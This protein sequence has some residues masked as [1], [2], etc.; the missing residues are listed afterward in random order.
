MTRGVGSIHSWPSE[1]EAVSVSVALEAI[2]PT[3]RALA[4][5][6]HIENRCAWVAYDLFSPCGP[7][8]T[9]PR[10]NCANHGVLRFEL[11]L[12]SLDLT[13]RNFASEGCPWVAHSQRL[14]PVRTL[15]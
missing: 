11:D 1:R 10:R 3:R 15:L 14:V 12:T 4:E 5:R 9:L 7:R 8:G 6:V 13:C 2:Q